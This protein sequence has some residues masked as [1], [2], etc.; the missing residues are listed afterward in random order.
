M[1]H[2]FKKLKVGF[3]C[4]A[5]C[6]GCQLVV[7]SCEELGELVR[8]IEVVNFREAT[9]I[10]QED[11]HVA[12]IEGSIT[13]REDARRLR[14]IRRRARIVVTLGACSTTGGIN[15]LINRFSQ[16]DAIGLVYGK[17]PKNRALIEGDGA[18]PADRF[19]KVDY[20]L[21]GCP[22]SKDEFVGLIKSLISGQRPSIPNYPVCSECKMAGN[23]C[24]FHRGKACMGPVTR[25]G[26]NALCVSYGSICWGCRSMFEGANIEAHIATL[27]R[28]GLPRS[29]IDG[30]IGL[31]NSNLLDH[32]ERC[33]ETNR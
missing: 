8:R 19:I 21:P 29:A 11:Y 32:T 20:H 26:C 22:I 23:I 13:R 25:G 28:F 31:Y 1:R 3:F 16:A 30:L 33:T 14:Q 12:F 6:E 17:N 4:F 7:L 10:K 27:E 9:D 24:T 15:G 5:S 18:L 2:L